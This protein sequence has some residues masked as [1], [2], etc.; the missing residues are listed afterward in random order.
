MNIS[1]LSN[2]KVKLLKFN[3][4]Y[5]LQA[6]FLH[7]FQSKYVKDI[8]VVN[9]LDHDVTKSVFLSKTTNWKVHTAH[10]MFEP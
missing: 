10:K 9:S 1:L 2:R 7:C 4:C 8:N 5:I 3:P 6:G